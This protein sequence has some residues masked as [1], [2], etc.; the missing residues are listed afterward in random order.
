[1]NRS[2]QAFSLAL[3]FVLAGL[4][5]MTA[6][7]QRRTY[8]TTNQQTRLLIRRIESRANIFRSS[9]TSALDNSRIDGTQREDNINQFVS[10][11]ESATNQLRDRINTRQVVAADVQNVLDR[12]ALID[13]FMRRNRLNAQAER[14]WASLRTDLN[15]LA[16]TYNIAWNWNTQTYPS[17][18]YPSSNYP[19]NNYPPAG[20]AANRLTGTYSLDAARS[21]DARNVAERS[22]R[23]LPYGDR[24]RVLDSLTARLESPTTIAIDRRGRNDQWQ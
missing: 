24:Q 1:M 12:A 14:D 4:G 17:N 22:A 2:R 23:S 6:Q 8:G 9:L 18:N 7:A 3:V 10:D 13:S 5:M 20:S 15:E 16:R 11:F 19:P 21:D